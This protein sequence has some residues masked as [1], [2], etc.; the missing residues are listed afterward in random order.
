MKVVGRDSRTT[1]LLMQNNPSAP[2]DGVGGIFESRWTYLMLGASSALLFYFSLFHFPAIPIW[3][4]GDQVIFLDHAARMVQGATLYRD[5]FQ[6]NLPAT[7]YLYY[8]LFRWW[9]IQLWI[10]PLVLLIT[11][12]V[13]TLVVFS[14]SRI[15][16][17][18]VSALLPPLV[19]LVV[20]QRYS[21]DGTHHW[22]STALVLLSVNL[23]ARARNPIPLNAAGALLGLATL[24]TSSRGMF[25]ITGVSLFFVWKFRGFRNAI[26][27]I[28]AL[29]WPFIVVTAVPIIALANLAGSRAFF[30]SVLIFPLRYYSAGHGNGPSMFFDEWRL[31]WPLGLHSFYPI[32]F[33]LAM[34]VAIPFLLIVFAVRW[35]RQKRADLRSSPANQI[36]FLYAVV[37]ISTLLPVLTTPSR[38]RLACAGSFA[39]ILGAKM[40]QECKRKRMIS[41][42]VVVVSIMGIIEM[43][44][45]AV[46]SS[47]RF[48]SPLG[49]VIFQDRQLYEEYAWVAGES[50]PGDR[51]FGD[52]NFNFLLNLENP[53]KVQWVES[54]AYTRPEQVDDLLRSLK[55]Q[56]TRFIVWY[57]EVPESPG[58]GDVLLPF[59]AYVKQNY[60]LAKS[61]DDGIEILI[62]NGS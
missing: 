19:F 48:Q 40:L 30:W 34:N 47:E 7:E 42:I 20:C 46:R 1:A 18:G 61:F 8:F 24:F 41:G 32:A 45:G 6:F 54:D 37:A 35:C 60:H 11:Q 9:G 53:A 44:R 50:H 57:E 36:L 33:W 62:A 23:I 38:I 26:P 21:L 55:R 17:R 16:L 58:P 14:L 10:E 25:A 49:V 51:L 52:V 3:R 2:L 22:Y 4:P 27:A 13:I 12:T 59:R 5:L 39:Y 28:A 29:W 31:A 43:A 15:V 56:R